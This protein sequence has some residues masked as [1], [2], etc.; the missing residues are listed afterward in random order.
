MLLKIGNLQNDYANIVRNVRDRGRAVSPRG[1]ATYE[2]E[3]VIIEMREPESSLPIDR[4][5]KVSKALAAVEALQLIGGTS[6]PELVMRV[7]PNYK[8]FMSYDPGGKVFQHGAYGPRIASQVGR[9]VGKL[10]EDPTTRQAVIGIWSPSDLKVD[11]PDIPCT[12]ILRYSIRGNRLNATTFMR[13]NDVWWGLAY[14][15]FQFTQLQLTISKAL[16][17]S[18][19]TYTHHAASL[20]LYHRDLPSLADLT[21]STV[22]KLQVFGVGNET[23]MHWGWYA[24]RARRIL[25]GQPLDNPSRSERWYIEALRPHVDSEVNA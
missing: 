20:H 21:A 17:C 24:H 22:H 5:R 14:D 3:N 25:R 7:A 2:V 18:A 11:S 12:C 23:V 8:K 1:L 10:L 19:G 13:S 9:V 4:G 6:T 16:G 15:A